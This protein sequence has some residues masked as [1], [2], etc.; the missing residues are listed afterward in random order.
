MASTMRQAALLAALLLAVGPVVHAQAGARVAQPPTTSLAQPKQIEPS[1]QAARVLGWG[2]ARFGMTRQQVLQTV[3]PEFGD[4][5]TQALRDVTTD[6]PDN[7]RGLQGVLPAEHR[8]AGGRVVYAFDRDD[9]LAWVALWR[10]TAR[11][12]SDAVRAE[13][14]ALASDWVAELLAQRWRPFTTARGV[15]LSDTDVVVLSAADDVGN[16]VEVR[17]SNVAFQAVQPDGT[18]RRLRAPSD[19][20]QLR[21]LFKQDIDG[22]AVIAPGAF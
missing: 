7:P 6:D 18:R 17:L 9:R 3:Q 10:S 14:T 8:M 13:L 12:A 16:G 1:G 2:A 15:V 20:A 22:L 21:V 5:W 19:A 11:G 4:A